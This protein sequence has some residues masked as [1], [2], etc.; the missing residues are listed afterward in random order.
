MKM[1]EKWWRERE[2]NSWICPFDK[3]TNQ[4][5]NQLA[6]KKDMSEYVSSLA[7]VKKKKTSTLKST[8]LL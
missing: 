8:V 7:E 5:T 6:K 3:P 4:P 2:S 1:L